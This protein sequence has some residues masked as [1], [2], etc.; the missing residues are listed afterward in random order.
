MLL[1]FYLEINKELLKTL[2]NIVIPILFVFSFFDYKT[3]LSLK[4]FFSLRKPNVHPVGGY[5]LKCDREAVF[6]KSIFSDNRKE[7]P[8]L[9]LV[10]TQ[11]RFPVIQNSEDRN[12][13]IQMSQLPLLVGKLP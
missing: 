10:I 2:S 7:E 1:G 11:R 6:K 9:N 8:T 13:L 5:D 3:Q 12:Y 4:S